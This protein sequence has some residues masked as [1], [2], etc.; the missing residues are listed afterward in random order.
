M[1][2]EAR[3]LSHGFIPGLQDAH[4]TASRSPRQPLESQKSKTPN[5]GELARQ[6]H[7]IFVTPRSPQTPR[8]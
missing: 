8:I 5:L 3:P 4:E 2:N 1:I 6:T 7:D